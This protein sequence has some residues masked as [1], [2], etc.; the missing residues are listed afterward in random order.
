MTK[1][2]SASDVVYLLTERS[3]E[4]R[5]VEEPERYEKDRTVN[6]IQCFQRT[7]EPLKL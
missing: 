3:I 7:F 6:F 4:R 5:V 1:L 2:D